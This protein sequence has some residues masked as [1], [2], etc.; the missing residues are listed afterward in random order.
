[1]FCVYAK[2]GDVRLRLRLM[3]KFAL[4]LMR[5]PEAVAPARGEAQAGTVARIQKAE[6]LV[7][8]RILPLFLEI[9]IQ[10]VLVAQRRVEA[11]PDIVAAG[12]GP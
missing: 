2:Y 5:A 10:A 11:H 6:Q 9:E 12:S 7:R 4:L 1:M 8:V 3:E